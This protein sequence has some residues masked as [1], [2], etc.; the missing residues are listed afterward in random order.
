VLG[1]RGGL[2]L[3]VNPSPFTSASASALAP[4]EDATLPD[5]DVL[6]ERSDHVTSFFD[7]FGVTGEDAIYVC[8]CKYI[9][10][11]I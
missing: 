5:S 11:Y 8:V 2:G 9:Y 4:V 6:A 3:R 7:A 1:E 10:I